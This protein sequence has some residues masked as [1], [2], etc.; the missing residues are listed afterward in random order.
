MHWVFLSIFL[1]VQDTKIQTLKTFYA[2]ANGLQCSAIE[3]R[4]I[5]V[6]WLQQHN[7]SKY[8]RLK[9]YSR[10]LQYDSM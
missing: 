2:A 4:A 9:L 1:R 5:L 7:I 6:I 8:L 3:M 10:T